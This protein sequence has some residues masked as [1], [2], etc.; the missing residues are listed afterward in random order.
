[1]AEEAAPESN[2]SSRHSEDPDYRRLWAMSFRKL[3]EIEEDPDNPLHEKAKVV[4]REAAA[5]IRSAFEATTAP[6]AKQ[7]SAGLGEWVRQAVGLSFKG[8]PDAV[9]SLTH[10]APVIDPI[11]HVEASFSGSG[12]LDVDIEANEAPDASAAEVQDA[13]Q[14]A[15]NG[16]L[17]QIVVIQQKQLDNQEAEA[18]KADGREKLNRGILWGTLT[19]AVLTFVATVVLG[20][21]GF[22]ENLGP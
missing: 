13:M 22:L 5:P 14:V 7:F 6:L 10:P 2:E 16:F 4:G 11:P 20:L 19:A 8:L 15:A 3:I 17:E 18:G 1:M 9:S 21:P 12:R